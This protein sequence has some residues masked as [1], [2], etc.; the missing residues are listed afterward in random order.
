MEEA[1]I[2]LEN[3]YESLLID[4]K[5]RK[6][7][8]FVIVPKEV[9]SLLQGVW[10]LEQQQDD[11]CFVR[12]PDSSNSINNNDPTVLV[13][14]PRTS[15]TQTNITHAPKKKKTKMM[16]KEVK[17]KLHSPRERG[18]DGSHNVDRVSRHMKAVQSYSDNLKNYAVQSE[19]FPCIGADAEIFKGQGKEK[20]THAKL[21][22]QATL[23]ETLTQMGYMSYNKGSNGIGDTDDMDEQLLLQGQQVDFHVSF[24]QTVG[25]SM[26]QEPHIDFRWDRVQQQPHEV[27]EEMESSSDVVVGGG[28]R[29]RSSSSS[30]TRRCHA[31][32]RCRTSKRNRKA[33]YMDRVPFVAFVPLVKEGMRIELWKDCTQMVSKPDELEKKVI[34]EGDD[35][36][37]DDDASDDSHNHYNIGTLVDIPLGI[38]LLVRGDVVH[39]GGFMTANNGNPRVHLY[40]Y[41]SFLG[42][43]HAINT[44]NTYT[45]P[46]AASQSSP[47]SNGG[48]SSPS[49][50]RTTT[51]TTTTKTRRLGELYKHAP[52]V[53][54]AKEVVTTNS[55][56]RISPFLASKHSH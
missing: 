3:Q 44:S 43:E 17:T 40:I 5:G 6:R 13:T 29:K 2:N 37:D 42:E 54:T 30:P 9:I 41:R 21:Q 26:A 11:N 48:S 25:Q 24:L 38:L 51:T 52:G 18:R 20:V 36:G 22:L 47:S 32:Q 27:A 34:D 46:A 35:V 4:A 56:I 7:A 31:R 55:I 10:N 39:A 19:G 12:T 8:R 15:S 53:T 1:I 45:F 28:G 16:N 50:I 33:S 49:R 23:A 14:P